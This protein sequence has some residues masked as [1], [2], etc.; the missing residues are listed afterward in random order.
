M[1]KSVEV[2]VRQILNEDSE[3][4]GNLELVLTA[5]VIT[6][7]VEMGNV[8]KY[9]NLWSVSN[10]FISVIVFKLEAGQV[11]RNVR[12]VHLSMCLKSTFYSA[13]KFQGVTWN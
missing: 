1:V 10:G 8:R 13:S 2:F 3:I 5:W 7:E 6:Q 12:S 9:S 4:T 11:F